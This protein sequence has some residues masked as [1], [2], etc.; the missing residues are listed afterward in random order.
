MR[1]KRG[2]YSGFCYRLYPFIC[3]III[4]EGPGNFS[5]GNSPHLVNHINMCLYCIMYLLCFSP[6]VV[7]FIAPRS[8]FSNSRHQEVNTCVKLLLSCYHCRYLWL[9]RRITVDPILVHQITNLSVK[10]PESQKFYL[11]KTSD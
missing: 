3:W 1:E 10:G 9:D 11:G 6:T 5:G 7:F 8:Y 2:S 4:K